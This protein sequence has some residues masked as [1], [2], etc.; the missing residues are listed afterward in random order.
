M[1]HARFWKC[2]SRAL[3]LGF[4]VQRLIGVWVYSLE[5]Q[6]WGSGFKVQ[7]ARFGLSS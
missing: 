4:K 7:G 3:G 1:V 2:L 6:V 5:F